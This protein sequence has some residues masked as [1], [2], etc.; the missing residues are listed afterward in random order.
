MKNSK[1]CEGCG[2]L[3]QSTD[4]NKPGYTPKENST[5]CMECFK[6]LNYGEK[7]NN[8]TE[9][10]IEDYLNIIKKDDSEVF[11]V[12]DVL[13][14]Y[15]TIINDLNKYIDEDRLTLIINKVDVLPKAIKAETIIDYI[16][17]ISEMRNVR[18][19]NISL[20]SSLKLENIDAIY[21]YIQ[22]LDSRVSVIGYSNVGKSSFIKGLFKSKMVKINNLTSY[23]IGTTL[24]PIT[25]DLDG[26]E[27]VDYPGF[28]LK[29]NYQNYL[30]KD[31]LKLTIPRKE[32]KIKT[33]Q[34]ESEQLININDLAFFTVENAESKLG[35]Q[36]TF[37]NDYEISRHKLEKGKELI[38][39][40]FVKKEIK[41]L[42]N[43]ERQDIIIT[44]IG[45]ITF[46]NLGEKLS[47]Y[48]PEEVSVNVVESIY[49]ERD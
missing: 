39:N 16:V 24:E 4:Q 35:Y 49:N 3:L 22:S 28:F 44:G 18:F 2:V 12:V 5:Y 23:T 43:V 37:S 13:N 17:N 7:E 47:I 14:P 30:D 40:K 46:L 41:P 25:L 34:L 10:K 21:N 32:I 1:R 11:L 42:P 27:I 20:V 19:K 33:Y 31:M 38:P 6:S 9:F 26:K 29:S 45:T 15:E 36:F 48:V 8:L